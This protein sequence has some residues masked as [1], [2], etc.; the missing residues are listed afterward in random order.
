M[1]DPTTVGAAEVQAS[2]VVNCVHWEYNSTP[3]NKIPSNVATNLEVSDIL[4][5]NDKQTKLCNVNREVSYWLKFSEHQTW[6]IKQ[7]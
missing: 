5:S 1:L 3:D 6:Q 4:N 2:V 7:V